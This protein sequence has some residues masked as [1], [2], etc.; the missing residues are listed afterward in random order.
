MPQGKSF[1]KEDIKRKITKYPK[2]KGNEATSYRKYDGIKYAQEKTMAL[3]IFIIK[4]EMQ[5]INIL[6]N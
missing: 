5:E 4:E 3:S 6:R 1:V 2:H